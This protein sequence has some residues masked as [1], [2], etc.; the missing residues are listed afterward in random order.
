LNDIVYIRSKLLESR[1]HGIIPSI[2]NDIVYI[3]SK[4][5][6]YKVFLMCFF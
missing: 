2:L 6:E 4:W 3:F 5:K 1:I